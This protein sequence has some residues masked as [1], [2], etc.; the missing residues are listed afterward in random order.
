MKINRLGFKIFLLSLLISLFIVERYTADKPVD[1]SAVISPKST[2]SPLLNKANKLD[3]FRKRYGDKISNIFNQMRASGHAIYADEIISDFDKSQHSGSEDFMVALE[4]IQKA[5]KDSPIAQLSTLWKKKSKLSEDDIKKIR[6]LLGDASVEELLDY[7]RKASEKDYLD[8]KLDYS[9]GPNLL[10][11]HLG[12]T[13]NLMRI[14]S[15]KSFI[16]SNEG[17]TEEAV[18]NLNIALKLNNM[19]SDDVKTCCRGAG[20]AGPRPRQ[21]HYPE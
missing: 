17:R 20:G 11:P 7:A 16:D 5:D 15:L 2:K 6:E 13:R 9:Q 8:F 21:K 1:E 14:L 10:L 12:S 19:A 3:F 18:N 4:M